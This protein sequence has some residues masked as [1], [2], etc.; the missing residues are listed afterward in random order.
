MGL[1]VR[2]FQAHDSS[3]RVLMALNSRVSMSKRSP[4]SKGGGGNG[5]RQRVRFKIKTEVERRSHVF[6]PEDQ[7]LQR[8]KSF[9]VVFLSISFFRLP[10]VISFG[11]QY[12]IWDV[13]P[14]IFF[15][16]DNLIILN[17]AFYRN[18]ALITSRSEIFKRYMDPAN[19]LASDRASFFVFFMEFIPFYGCLAATHF[20]KAPWWTMSICCL[21]RGRRVYDLLAFFYQREVREGGAREREKGYPGTT[22]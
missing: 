18:D 9:G 2:W 1:P 13:V 22:Y 3:Y 20:L 4:K 16:L 7:R 17:T 5:K 10:M 8:W 6:N 19:F 21:F 14:D 15:F 12:I 11:M